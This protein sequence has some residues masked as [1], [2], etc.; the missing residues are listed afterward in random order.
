MISILEL[1]V[2]SGDGNNFIEGKT[3][4]SDVVCER[5]H[6]HTTLHTPLPKQHRLTYATIYLGTVCHFDEKTGQAK[7][8]LFFWIRP[9]QADAAYFFLVLS[10]KPKHR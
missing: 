6:Y 1:T 10:E 5:G 4:N 2:M 3:E 9:N 7:I 8:R